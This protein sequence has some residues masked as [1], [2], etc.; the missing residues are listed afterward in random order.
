VRSQR[1]F[2]GDY[3]AKLVHEGKKAVVIIS[4]ALRYEI[5]EELGSRI[6][7]E[8]R[9]DASLEPLLGVLPSYTQLGM[10]ALLPHQ[11]I[12]L[13]PDGRSVLV[14][15]QPTNGTE[16]RSKVLEAVH[17]A[18][19]QA[20]NFK[21]LRPEERRELFKNNRVLYVY[22]NR[23]D[24]IGDKLGTERQVFEAS[25]DTLRDLVDLVKKAANAN[26]TNIFVTAD[27]GFLF[28]NEGLPE[29]FFLSETPQGDDIL[30][31]NRRYVLGRGLKSDQAFT[32]FSPA[33][34]DFEGDIEVQIPK[35]IQR[36]KLPGGGSRFVH[37]G[38]TL[39]EVVV[40]VLSINKKRKSDTRPVNVKVLPDTDKIT[41]GQLVVKLFQS[42]TVT[43]KVQARVLRVGLYVGET[44]IS[45]YP[46]P[47][48]TFDS[49]SSDQRDRY[50][51]VQL[52]LTNEANDHNNRA[53][54][55]RL[56]EQVPNTNH[57]RVYEKATYTLQRS[58]SS[59]FDF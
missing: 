4:D 55:F 15:G 49:T 6:R 36:L 31:K 42:E 13:S 28:Q 38:A 14:D 18:A 47:E 9:F 3:V 8:D 39:Q 2:Y 25:D 46:Q 56:E 44:L 11:T 10:A 40:P 37:G 50:Q 41:T 59:D 22:H 53:V 21:A 7:Q 33:Q 26:A 23:I 54:E 43:D 24:A 19:I 52:L 57:W 27:H 30:V 32:T 12:S 5:A 20:E 17:G 45:N 48:L 1:S 34:L 58:F 51:S 35:S 16:P 29:Q